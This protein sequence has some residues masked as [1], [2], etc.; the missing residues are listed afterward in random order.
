MAVVRPHKITKG[1]TPYGSATLAISRRIGPGSTYTT[2]DVD[3]ERDS[4]KTFAFRASVQGSWFI[5]VAFAGTLQYLNYAQGT[6][7]AGQGSIRTAS[8]D[9]EV[10]R[11][12]ARVRLSAAG[13]ASIYYGGG[14]KPR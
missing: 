8:F 4:T 2:D 14:L 3:V 9:E 7:P 11:A 12:R 5:Q 10:R 1:L 13:S 6:F